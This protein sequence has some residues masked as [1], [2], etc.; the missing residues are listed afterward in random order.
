MAKIIAQYITHKLIHYLKHSL[1]KGTQD[2]PSL[3]KGRLREKGPK[4]YYPLETSLSYFCDVSGKKMLYSPLYGGCTLF[5]LCI[6]SNRSE[7]KR[8]Q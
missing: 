2:P 5:Y 6:L 3:N 1:K 7:H 8:G 4:N